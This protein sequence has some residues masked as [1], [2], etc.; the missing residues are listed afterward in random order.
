MS[1][2]F[3][4]RV[5]DAACAQHWAMQ[6]EPLRALLEVAAREPGPA[7]E[8]LAARNDRPLDNAHRTTVRD[9][10]AIVPVLGPLFR[11]ATRIANEMLRL[12]N[13]DERAARGE[14]GEGGKGEPP[15]A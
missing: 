6:E 5:F 10:V 4:S 2:R 8:A 15:K 7:L 3:P 13:A 9:G 12:L 1:D 11:Y 14:D